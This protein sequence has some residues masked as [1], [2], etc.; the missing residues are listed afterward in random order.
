MRSSGR[1]TS[2]NRSMVF[3]DHARSSCKSCSPSYACAARAD[4]L[5]PWRTSTF[6]DRIVGLRPNFERAATSGG[7]SVSWTWLG[8]PQKGR[9][10]AARS[11]RHVVEKL[12]ILLPSGQL[13]PG[14]QWSRPRSTPACAVDS[15]SGRAPARRP[16][17]HISR[18]ESP[19][20]T[21]QKPQEP[22]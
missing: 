8:H 2:T 16:A 15:Y 7:A 14:T 4:H 21:L 12:Q 11:L 20:Q 19:P 10:A 3:T 6:I 1:S 5:A 17:T 9:V 18:S 22:L 13:R